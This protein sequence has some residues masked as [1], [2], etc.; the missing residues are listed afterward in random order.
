MTA[1]SGDTTGAQEFR[2]RGFTVA[3]GFFSKAEVASVLA[4]VEQRMSHEDTQDQLT[5]GGLVF[6]SNVFRQSRVVQAFLTQ[7]RLIDFLEPIAGGDLW[8]RWDQAVSKRPG[9][10]E[11]R[12]HQDNGYNRL[13]T[14]HFQCWIALTETRNQ[15]GA[16]WL[17]P[18]SHRRGLLPHERVSG[19]QIEVRAEVGETLCIDATA[20]DMVVFSSLMLHRTGPNEA[21][22]TRVAY[23]AEYMPLSDYDHDVKGP[24]FI[25]AT[26][27]RSDPRFVRRPPGALSLRNQLLYAGPRLSRL[28]G[29]ARQSLRSLLHL[30]GI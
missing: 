4:E 29:K 1:S 25:A 2:E 19:A 8:V 16:L 22:S 13:R 5:D 11:F 12:W 30:P 21:D 26:G 7:Q 27:G 10:G 20:G 18:G 28:A 14:E 24:Y 6:T 3:R 15:N 17:A 23:V 9:A